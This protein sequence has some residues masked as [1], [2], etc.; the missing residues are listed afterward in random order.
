MALVLKE[1]NGASFGPTIKD[2]LKEERARKTSLEARGIGIIT[3]SGVLATL[4]FGLVTFTR[5]QVAQAHLSITE[6]AKWALILGVV[7]FGVAALAGLWANLPM[8]YQ[9]ASS[10]ELSNRVKP[11]NWFNTQPI[12][13]A[14]LDAKLLVETIKLARTVNEGKAWAVLTGIV[15]EGLAAGAVAVA[16]L[17]ELLE[18]PPS[19]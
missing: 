15:A 17:I 8:N 12:E 14:R 9:E 13:A 19:R 1:V 2:Q 18:L 4:L 10:Q 3:S 6:P 16:V 11:Q 5:G 7:L